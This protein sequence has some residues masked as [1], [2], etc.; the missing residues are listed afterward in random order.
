MTEAHLLKVH[1]KKINYKHVHITSIFIWVIIKSGR[2]NPMVLLATSDSHNDIV[3]LFSLA[4]CTFML[5]QG[6]WWPHCCEHTSTYSLI[7]HS[8]QLKFLSVW[9]S[10][11]A[12]V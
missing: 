2:V 1:K 5:E 7:L 11:V 4:H 10:S 8:I 12:H 6:H 9:L 3:C